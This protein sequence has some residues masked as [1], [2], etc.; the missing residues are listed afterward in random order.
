MQN[1]ENENKEYWYVMLHLD[2]SL[3]ERQLLQ[4]NQKRSASGKSELLY[5]IPF[6]YL[7]RATADHETKS[8]V[9]LREIDENNA[10]RD[11]LHDFV[12]IKASEQEITELVYQPW[13]REGRLHLRFYRTHDKKAIR[14]PDSEMT[15][16]IRLMVEQRQ[17]FSFESPL[18]N[19]ESLE[20]VIIKTGLFKDYQASVIDYHYTADGIRFTL[21][22]PVFGGVRTLRLPDYSPSD[23]KV[24]GTLEQLLDTNF[25]RRV[26]TGLME[27]L[28]RR[29]KGRIDDDTRREDLEQLNRFAAFNYLKFDDTASHN[30]FRVLMLLCAALRRDKQTK[31][32]LTALVQTFVADPLNPATD[33]EA[34]VTAV[35][36]VATRNADYRTAAKQYASTRTNLHPS[37][38]RI[39]PMIKDIHTR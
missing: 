24:K 6:R 3:I 19:L 15:P 23:V 22:I 28:R 4:M 16:L 11:N 18:D 37:L 32:E 2:P 17:K 36:F 38:Q 27:I 10:L 9:K 7:K 5:V 20:N 35:L 25:I 12:F 21:A 33:D 26:E 39:M 34:F 29:V 14:V 8:R 31:E 13:N 30:H 1:A